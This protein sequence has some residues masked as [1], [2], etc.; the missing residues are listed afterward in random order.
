MES[1]VFKAT[2]SLWLLNDGGRLVTCSPQGEE[3]FVGFIAL[4]EATIFLADSD[5]DKNL[6]AAKLV[7]E[8]L[9]VAETLPVHVFTPMGHDGFVSVQT[10]TKEALCGK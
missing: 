8:Q 10:L 2:D 6:M 9:W 4:E 3:G 5:W 7:L 1:Q